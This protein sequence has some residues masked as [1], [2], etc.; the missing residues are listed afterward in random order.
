MNNLRCLFHRYPAPILF[1]FALAITPLASG[2]PADLSSK[3]QLTGVFTLPKMTLQLFAPKN[4]P[5]D[6]ES[7]R[8]NG[9]N[10]TDLPSIGSG[11]ARRTDGVW[12]GI[13]DRGPNSSVK[14]Q[15]KLGGDRRVMPL[16]DFCPFI[17]QMILTNSE[18]QLPQV[19]PLTDSQGQPLTGLNNSPDEEAGFAS[20]TAAQPLPP[21]P[22]GLDP[23][24]IRCLPDGNFIMG[25]EYSPSIFVVSANGEVL[26]RY[27]P[28]SKPLTGARYPV[29]PI[30]PDILRERRQNRGFESLALSRDGRTAYA[31][32]QSPMGDAKD[33]HYADSRIIRAVELDL[34]DPLK[35]RVK[36][37]FLLRASPCS[38]Y[39]GNERQDQVKFNDAEWLAPR[40]LLLLEQAKGRAQL[41]V[42][43]FNNATDVLENPDAATLRFEDTATDL[44][45]LKISP[46]KTTPIFSTAD[47]PAIDSDKLEGLVLLGADE[48]ALSNDNDFGIGDNTSAQ[49]SKVWTIR[50]PALRGVVP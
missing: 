43:D 12:F 2:Q 28:K 44:A 34:T 14:A 30:L 24:C 22:G 41:I 45:A 47:I 35:A 7:A 13:S 40:R 33:P 6:L 11:L 46:A 39:P 29:Q 27:S 50:L 36:A 42:A 26:M 32:L 37:M 49:P 25:E 48:I 21:D 8:T 15:K 4:H 16:P 10:F 19:I 1:A 23:E 9:L 31:I 5:Y 3:P 20:P 17:V 38:D 18:I